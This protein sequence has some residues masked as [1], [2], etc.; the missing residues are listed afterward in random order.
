[1]ICFNGLFLVSSVCRMCKEKMQTNPTS[2]NQMI[3][4]F[5]FLKDVIETWH[6]M[7]GYSLCE[8]SLW[9]TAS[10]C[11]PQQLKMKEGSFACSVQCTPKRHWRFF[12]RRATPSP[13]AA[14]SC[15]STRSTGTG[16]PVS[17]TTLNTFHLCFHSSHL[18]LPAEAAGCSEFKSHSKL[19]SVVSLPWQK[20]SLLSPVHPWTGKP[21]CDNFPF[22]HRFRHLEEAL[23]NQRIILENVITKVEEKKNGIQVSAKQIEDR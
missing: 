14:A 1:M 10:L 15:P 21:Q 19:I 8:L 6:E 12:V 23:Q 18:C 11:I 22:F 9:V 20:P 4:G 16:L 17:L 7:V 3:P 2:D 5:V 13:A